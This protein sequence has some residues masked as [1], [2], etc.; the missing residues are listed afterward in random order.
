MMVGTLALGVIIGVILSGV[1]AVVVANFVSPPSPEP[2][3]LPRVAAVGVDLTGR[4]NAPQFD[5][6]YERLLRPILTQLQKEGTQ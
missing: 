1:V 2:A 3:P 4:N 5:P 6:H